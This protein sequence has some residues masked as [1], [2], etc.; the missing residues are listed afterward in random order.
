MIF[1]KEYFK[2]I[3]M[4]LPKGWEKEI[5]NEYNYISDEEE[6]R[7]SQNKRKEAPVSSQGKKQANR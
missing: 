1:W 4:E 5:V 6:S 2:G 3:Q 7:K